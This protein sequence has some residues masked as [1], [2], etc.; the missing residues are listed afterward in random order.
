M[1]PHARYP[2]TF[3]TRTPRRV[4]LKRFLRWLLAFVVLMALVLATVAAIARMHNTEQQLQDAF[5]KGMH[6]GFQMCP[7]GE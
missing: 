5:T 2:Y 7:L 3:P 1:S 6:A 4:R